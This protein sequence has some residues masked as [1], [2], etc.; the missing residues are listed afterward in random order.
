MHLPDDV[1][2]LDLDWSPLPDEELRSRAVE[3]GKII[4]RDHDAY[5]RLRLA[6]TGFEIWHLQHQRDA[7]RRKCESAGRRLR[8][9]KDRD[10]RWQ[11]QVRE[12]LGIPEHD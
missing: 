7:F 9:I 3:L 6:E 12:M 1:N 8:K 10:S 5:L 11:K 2:V 4:A